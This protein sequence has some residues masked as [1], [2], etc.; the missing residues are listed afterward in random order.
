MPLNERVVYSSNIDD[1]TWWTAPM[2][3]VSI[4]LAA[5]LGFV[6]LF[7]ILHLQQ[8]RQMALEEEMYQSAYEDADLVDLDSHID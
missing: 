8:R 6:I 3:P 7:V 4:T 2:S 1:A 5:L